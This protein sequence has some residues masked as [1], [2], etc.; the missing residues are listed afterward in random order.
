M[1]LDTLL[2]L[3]FELVEPLL[4]YFW[5]RVVP[6]SV[7]SCGSHDLKTSTTD[8]VGGRAAGGSGES[9]GLGDRG[10]GAAAESPGGGS[11]SG[12][13]S[14]SSRGAGRSHWNHPARRP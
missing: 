4:K 1:I 5:Y 8:G 10:R 3:Q 2:L 7:V 11:R 9:R 12:L 13:R 14:G 6:C